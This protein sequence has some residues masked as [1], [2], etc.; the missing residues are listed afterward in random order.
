MTNKSLGTYTADAPESVGSKY[1]R[2][3]INVS[4]EPLKV[5]GIPLP[6]YDGLVLPD[7]EYLSHL[8]SSRYSSMTGKDFELLPTILEGLRSCANTKSGME[9]SHLGFSIELALNSGARPFIITNSAGDYL[10]V[11]L[12]GRHLK[13]FKNRQ[14]HPVMSPSQVYRFFADLNKHGRALQGL[15]E[16]INDLPDSKMAE[17]VQRHDYIPDHFPY[18]RSIHNIVRQISLDPDQ[19]MKVKG[20]LSHLSYK[21]TYWSATD[22][23]KLIRLPKLIAGKVFL[24]NKAPILYRDLSI[25]L[26]SNSTLSTL[27]AFGTHTP[28]FSAKMGQ[29]IQIG[30]PTDNRKTCFLSSIAGKK[31]PII[32][33]L[34]VY[35]LPIMDATSIWNDIILKGMMRVQV[36]NNRVSGCKTTHNAK[37]AIGLAICHELEHYCCD[38]ISK[39]AVDLKGKGTKRKADDSDKDK[40]IKR[41]KGISRETMSMFASL[42]ITTPTATAGLDQEESIAASDMED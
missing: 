17:S 16:L 36:N 31:K 13:I 23:D 11:L 35:V 15:C 21:Q 27:S 37:S 29:V 33:S 3:V 4:I 41:I 28:T 40:G 12:R 6:Y 1:D 9:L 24:D 26:T 2:I 42:G 19:A 10:G 39:N 34:P 32:S 20:Y 14:L 25:M 8:V 22:T 38:L 30:A 5:Y 7:K 18:P